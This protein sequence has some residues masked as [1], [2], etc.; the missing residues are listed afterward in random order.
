MAVTSAVRWFYPR[1]RSAVAH[2]VELHAI[3]DACAVFLRVDQD[4]AHCTRG[5]INDVIDRPTAVGESSVVSDE[6]A[7]TL[8]AADCS[9][10]NSSVQ[11]QQVRDRTGVALSTTWTNRRLVLDQQEQVVTRRRRY[12]NSD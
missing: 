9:W 7:E 2:F 11:A 8:L 5:N 12:G 1:E 4:A 3:A 10:R 6:E